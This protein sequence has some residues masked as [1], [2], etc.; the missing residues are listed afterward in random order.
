MLC[1]IAVVALV[2]GGAARADERPNE[3]VKSGVGQ[4][5]IC[6]TPAQAERYVTLRDGGVEAPAALSKV[7]EEANDP[8]AC[9]AALIAF[10]QGEALAEKNMQGKAVT[11]VRVTI[12]AFNDGTKWEHVPGTV[13]YTVVAAKGINI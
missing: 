11:I 10:T 7:N 9:G 1:G 2:I 13:Q 6:N 5:I 3:D 8:R 12:V 4:G